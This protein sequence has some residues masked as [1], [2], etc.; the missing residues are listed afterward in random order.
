MQRVLYPAAHMQDNSSSD[1]G[2]PLR[3]V[4]TGCTGFRSSDSWISVSPNYNPGSVV[5]TACRLPKF[6]HT[7]DPR[8]VFYC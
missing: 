2:D 8:D 3:L 6:I 5:R 1:S 7:K 4:A